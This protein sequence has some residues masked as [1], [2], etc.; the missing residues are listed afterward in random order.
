MVPAGLIALSALLSWWFADQL[1]FPEEFD[2]VLEAYLFDVG[3]PILQRGVELLWQALEVLP[4]GRRARMRSALA[5]G[6]VRAATD[7]HTVFSL[8]PETRAL[9]GPQVLEVLR[10]LWPLGL[11]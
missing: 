1:V 9:V 3:R 6:L 8:A 2:D 5:S 4:E 10:D 7:H 11:L